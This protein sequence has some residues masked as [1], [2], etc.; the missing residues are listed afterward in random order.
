MKKIFIGMILI[1][2]G[3]ATLFV[4]V[5]AVD[6]GTGEEAEESVK[7]KV[8]VNES[9]SS[10]FADAAESGIDTDALASALGQVEG[11]DMSQILQGFEGLDENDGLLGKLG[12]LIGPDSDGVA[13]VLAGLFGQGSSQNGTDA[14]GS[15][16]G[17]LGS[18][19]GNGSG[20]GILQGILDGLG[21][22]GNTTP[23]ATVHTTASS[24][25]QNVTN[26]TVYVPAIP[27][28]QIT[29]PILDFNQYTTF[30]YTLPAVITTAEVT[31]QLYPIENQSNANVSI[32]M[33]AGNQQEQQKNTNWKKIV[34]VVLVVAAFGAIAAVVIK[35]SM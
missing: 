1:L 16:G 29:Q 19:G 18:L 30:N 25:N 24:F 32:V 12:S 9:L 28:Q 17:G 26:P 23:N 15:S 35:K 21:N 22:S 13:G 20:G 14:N 8:E 6:S 27:Q 34:G 10:L 3:V 33:P 11:L 4:S 5:T 2:L 7:D 31:T